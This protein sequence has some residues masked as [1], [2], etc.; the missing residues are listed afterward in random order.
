MM[1]WDGGGWVGWDSAVMELQSIDGWI[2]QTNE[3]DGGEI[4]QHCSILPT[5]QFN[6]S[7]SKGNDRRHGMGEDA[8][9]C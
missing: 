3:N 8:D 9:E 6:T 5:P 1:R 4:V 7:R 2:S